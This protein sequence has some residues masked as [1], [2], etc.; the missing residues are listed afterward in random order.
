MLEAFGCVAREIAQHQQ[1]AEQREDAGFDEKEDRAAHDRRQRT[2]AG[3]VCESVMG[4]DVRL[5]GGR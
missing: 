3:I 5:G 1:S 2:T 4:G